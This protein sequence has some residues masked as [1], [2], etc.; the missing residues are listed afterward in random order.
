MIPP[1]SVPFFAKYVSHFTVF[2]FRLRSSQA[3]LATPS[4]SATEGP[5]WG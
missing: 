5:W 3:S 2:F 1:G 4:G